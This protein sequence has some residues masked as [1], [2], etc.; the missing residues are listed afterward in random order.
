MKVTVYD[1]LTFL[2]DVTNNTIPKQIPKII[3]LDVK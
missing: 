2:K 3:F 1:L